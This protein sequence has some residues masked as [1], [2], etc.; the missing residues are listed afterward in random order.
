MIQQQVTKAIHFM[1]LAA[2]DIMKTPAT[3]S[4]VLSTTTLTVYETNELLDGFKLLFSSSDYDE[5]V[6]LLTLAPSNW[7]RVQM[8]N[9][10]NC[11]QWQARKALELRDA[12]GFL[13]KVTN[14]AGN[15][16]L[17]PQLVDDIKNFYEE[18]GV[19]RQTANKKE[20]I[21]VNRQPIPIRYMSMTV[22]QA[23]SM[24]IE[25]LA[26]TSLVP[27]PSKSVFY[28]LRPRWIKILSPQDVCACVYHENFDFLIKVSI[29]VNKLYAR[30]YLLGVE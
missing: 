20:V 7:G 2:D 3:A 16:P 30:F 11:N 6:R 17:D 8:E 13:A 28:F 24:F 27:L 12:Y 10:F 5:Q 14:F 19:S 25:K 15:L 1:K 29:L 26:T 4:T 18:D 9:F 22:G 21:H 23:Y